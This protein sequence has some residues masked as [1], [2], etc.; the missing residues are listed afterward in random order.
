MN[1]IKDRLNHVWDIWIT[2]WKDGV[3]NQETYARHVEQGIMIHDIV[4]GTNS[5]KMSNDLSGSCLQAELC[6]CVRDIC[7]VLTNGRISRDD[8]PALICFL[9][10]QRYLFSAVSDVLKDIFS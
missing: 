10:Y 7:E 3:D 4:P 1:T 5:N 2:S 8:A 9:I 6:G